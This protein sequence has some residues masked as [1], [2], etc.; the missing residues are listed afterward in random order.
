MFVGIE[1]RNAFSRFDFDW[2]DLV[3]EFAIRDRFQ[4]FFLGSQR[5]L[6]LHFAGNVVFLRD[7]FGCHTHV[8]IVHRVGQRVVRHRVDNGLVAH[9]RSGTVFAIEQVRGGRHVFHTTGN[10]DVSPAGMNTDRRFDYGFKTGTAN[11]VDRVRWNGF[12]D[13]RVQ[14]DVT[15]DVLSQPRRDDVSD[16][17]FVDIGRL[18]PRFL[19]GFFQN[20]SP[21][22]SRWNRRQTTKKGSDRATFR[23]DNISFIHF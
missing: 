23:S 3:F 5:E 13:S 22:F 18:D 4:G 9:F 15:G 10:K 7:V 21:E 8:D 2:N 1:N 17:D 14:R 11:H 6:V 19:D 12:R 16:N 20:R